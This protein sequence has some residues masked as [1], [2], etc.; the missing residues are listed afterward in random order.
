[1]TIKSFFEKYRTIILE[2]ITLVGII[3]LW[4]VFK[5]QFD[6]NDDTGL[7]NY[8]A[9]YQ[10]GTPEI[11]PYVMCAPYTFLI[12]R[13]YILTSAVP[14]YTLSFMALQALSALTI[15]YSVIIKSKG[16]VA[17]LGFAVLAAMLYGHVLFNVQYTTVAAMC[18][19]GAFA[20]SSCINCT[21]KRYFRALAPILM[22]F[23][24]NIRYQ[25]G[26]VAMVIIL[27][28]YAKEMISAKEAKNVVDSAVILG[29]VIVTLGIN[30]LYLNLNGWQEFIELNTARATWIDNAHL[31]YEENADIYNDVG[32][33]ETLY[34]LA[35]KYMC[36]E[37]NLSASAYTTLNEANKA[38]IPEMNTRIKTALGNMLSQKYWM[39]CL[40]LWM[41]VLI[42]T[43]FYCGFLLKYKGYYRDSLPTLFFA[44]GM[45]GLYFA[46]F[47]Y[48]CFIG[49]T[50]P[51]IMYFISCLTITPGY[52]AIIES[53]EQGN[54]DTVGKN[55][56]FSVYAMTAISFVFAGVGVKT[57]LNI[58]GR[59]YTA[60]NTMYDYV[61]DHP[62]NFYF[63]DLSATW[64]TDPFRTNEVMPSNTCF[65]GGWLW[66]APL[67]NKQLAVNG[68]D[69][70]YLSTMLEDNKYF[71][72]SQD[73][74]DLLMEY[75]VDRYDNIRFEL[76]EE[77]EGWIVYCFR[78]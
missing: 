73:C 29:V 10:T 39:Q 71:I 30:S 61:I 28:Y 21:S 66:G 18:G 63:Y 7:L 6:T 50:M 57:M 62:T 75:Y 44:V 34:N 24:I 32:W 38:T 15:A 37:E 51:R 35:S 56:K 20:A 77:G 55:I 53:Y 31:Q 9:G 13:L 72:G 27:L 48:F 67:S 25:V 43:I 2:V 4:I 68:M 36:A 69:T 78:K 8:I 54:A 41:M 5:P 23:S 26:C 17:Y 22:F 46:L 45:F 65:W 49:R 11:V 64:A 12:S 60:S 74:A 42:V 76:I 47:F 3:L 52:I 1:M 40:V 14:W 33:D 59:D 19:A 16:V 70:C 58:G